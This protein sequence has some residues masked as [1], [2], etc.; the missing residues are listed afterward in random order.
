MVVIG[1]FARTP[2]YQGAGSSQVNPTRVSNALDELRTLAGSSL[3][4]D[5]APG[6]LIDATPGDAAAGE[7]LAAEA[8]ALAA[9]ADTVLLFLG[10]PPS[11]ES[12]GLGPRRHGPSGR[13]A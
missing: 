9:A 11:Y 12:E 2:R 3:R 10:L 4:I 1:E 5:F 8:T 13:A 7:G 6:Y